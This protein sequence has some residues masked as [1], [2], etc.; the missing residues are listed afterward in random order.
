MVYDVYFGVAGDRQLLSIGQI[1]SSYDPGIL[2]L[3]TTYEWQII[4]RDNYDAETAGPV[5]TFS[6]IESGI[7]SVT[8]ASGSPFYFKGQRYVSLPQWFLIT[9]DGTHFK[10][11]KSKVSFNDEG[12]KVLFSLP[13]S[14]IKI[15]VAAILKETALPGLHDV[16]VTTGAEVATGTAM[17][18]VNKFWRGSEQ[19]TVQLGSNDAVVDLK[20]LPV[21]LFKGKDALL[22]SEIIEKSNAVTTPENYYYN[23]IANDNYSLERGIILGD[24]EPG[25]HLGVTCKKATSTYRNHP[26]F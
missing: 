16:T 14:P 2:Q 11:L 9:G 8:P 7:A 12:I 21:H 24:G 23:F 1:A 20:G 6:T 17:F 25:F 5:W 3:A 13:I 26:G 4:A 19:I 15:W 18:E 22:L 10:F